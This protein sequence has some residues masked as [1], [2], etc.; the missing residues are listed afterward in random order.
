M[1]QCLRRPK[2]YRGL[3]TPDSTKA[4]TGEDPKRDPIEIA[5]ASA[6]YAIVLRGK[7]PVSGS[8]TP[9]KR[10]IEYKV[11]VASRTSTY[12]IVIT[13]RTNWPPTLV[14][15]QSCARS[16]FLMGWNA[17]TFLKNSNLASPTRV[18]G[19]NVTDVSLGQDIIETRPIPSIIAPRTLYVISLNIG[20]RSQYMS[21]MQFVH[22]SYVQRSED[23]AD[24][25]P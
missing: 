13:A 20:V 1:C 18:C 8:T 24:E 3:L 15:S 4:V 6:L 5:M 2:K 11:P 9:E 23:S 25:E 22:R 12:S 14:R 19:K 17:T 10:A 21:H 16:V 7:S